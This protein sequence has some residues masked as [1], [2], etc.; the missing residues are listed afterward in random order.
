M[1][2]TT[3]GCM[4]KDKGKGKDGGLFPKPVCPP[5]GTKKGFRQNEHEKICNDCGQSVGPAP[6]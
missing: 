5:H 3:L 2:R 4:G 1:A 6:H